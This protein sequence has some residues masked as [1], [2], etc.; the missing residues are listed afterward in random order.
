VNFT[1]Q[2]SRQ[3]ADFG[4]SMEIDPHDTHVSGAFQGA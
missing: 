3:V 1:P 2:Y 4:L